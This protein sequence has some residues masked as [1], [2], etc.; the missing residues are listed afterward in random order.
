MGKYGEPNA[1]NALDIYYHYETATRGKGRASLWIFC[2][3]VFTIFVQTKLDV[4]AI[5]EKNG[6]FTKIQL[7]NASR[8]EKTPEYKR[9]LLFLKISWLSFLAMTICIL[10][11][12]IVYY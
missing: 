11:Y 7:D 12:D 6:K 5:W 3:F 8:S 4:G 2:A 9:L 1:A 10:I